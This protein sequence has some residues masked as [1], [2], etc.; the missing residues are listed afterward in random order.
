MIQRFNSADPE[1]FPDAN[2]STSSG[3]Q[4]LFNKELY[5]DPSILIIDEASNLFQINRLNDTDYINIIDEFIGA[6]RNIKQNRSTYSVYAIAL[7]GTET[8][9]DVLIA[10]P[11]PNKKSIISPFTAEAS[12]E[13][14]RFTRPEI[15]NLLTQ[16]STETKI[17]LDTAGIA[18]SIHQLTLGHK[19]LTGCIGHYI[20][21]VVSRNR[22]R[23]SLEDWDRHAI[24]MAS[25]IAGQATYASIS[26]CLKELNTNQRAIMGTI[27]RRRTHIVRLVS[28]AVCRLTCISG[29]IF[30]NTPFSFYALM[31]DNDIK[32]LLAEGLV[33]IEDRLATIN[34][35]R[36][37]C[38]APIIRSIMLGMIQAPEVNLSVPVP[39]RNH[40]DPQWLLERTVEVSS[41]DDIGYG[42]KTRTFN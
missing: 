17:I 6:L 16:Y 42:S 28:S 15:E 40:L 7:V 1:R 25:F 32:F 21:H 20:E 31:K 8:V 37:E 11:L 18:D 5:P 10:R 29:F 12:F 38:S 41:R 39:D 24:N 36:I 35:V 19:G 4:K 13:P 22:C 14:D 2:T 26:S 3:F 27:L 23:V 34:E 30:I 33:V 9:R